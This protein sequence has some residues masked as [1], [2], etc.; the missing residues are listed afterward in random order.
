MSEQ[1]VE[2]TQEQSSLAKEPVSGQHSPEA[3]NT[4]T[5]LRS[6][7][8]SLKN[9]IRGLQGKMDKDTAAVEKRLMGRF[10]QVA[11]QLGVS[12]TP[13]QKMNLRV[14][15]LEEQLASVGQAEA[16]PQPQ[17]VKEPQ[18]PVDIAKIKEAY[19]DIDFNDPVV[20]SAL[21][22]NLFNEDGFLA[23]LGRVRLANVSKPQPTAASTVSPAGS[24]AKSGESI[25]ALQ[26]ELASLRSRDPYQWQ[27]NKSR[28]DEI[29]AKIQE[30][31]NA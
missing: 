28:R 20:T 1:N 16:K 3:S 27:A 19:K 2:G 12:L 5:A 22:S 30:L 7:L 26:K 24:V 10:E 15:E 14:M 17:T 9:E 8:D 23:A 11:G 18:Q 29:V 6:E 4:E 25:E 21:Q 13:E 31:D